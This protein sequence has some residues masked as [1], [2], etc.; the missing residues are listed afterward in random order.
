MTDF[1]AVPARGRTIEV[2][3]IDIFRFSDGQVVEHWHE[4]D[5]LTLYQQMGAEVRAVSE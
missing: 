3:A 1:E 5:H 2:T 4:T